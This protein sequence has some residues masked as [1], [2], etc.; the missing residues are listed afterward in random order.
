MKIQTINDNL[1]FKKI[2]KAGKSYVTKYLVIYYYKKSDKNL[3]SRFGYTVTKKIGN[4]VKRNRVRRLIK[5]AVRLNIGAFNQN[6]DYIIV[7]RVRCNTAS[8]KEVNDTLLN[9]LKTQKR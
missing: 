3:P 9:F 4:A 5:E 2:Y 8:Y 6:F 1:Y 7:A